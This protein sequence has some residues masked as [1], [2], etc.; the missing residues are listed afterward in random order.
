MRCGGEMYI[1]FY[2]LASLDWFFFVCVSFLSWN[3]LGY[4]TCNRNVW[5]GFREASI[6]IL[7]YYYFLCLLQ[8]FDFLWFLYF[9]VFPM[10]S[11]SS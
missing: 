4:W 11:S 7:Y 9:F 1:S 8:C 5:V 2:F 3:F 6:E 10:I